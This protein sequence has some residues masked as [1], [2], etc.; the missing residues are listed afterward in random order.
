MSKPA[1][2]RRTAAPKKRRKPSAKNPKPRIP[3][4]PT[5]TA[6]HEAGHAVI[7]RALTLACSGASNL[8]DYEDWSAGHAVVL[9]PYATV[10]EWEQ[11]G[12][13]RRAE[14]MWYGHI[15][16][17]MAGAEAEAILLGRAQGGDGKDRVV[18]WRL[19]DH[20]T[21]VP[22]IEEV[23]PDVP[24]ERV[25]VYSDELQRR[26]QVIEARL[27]RMTRMLVRHHR[28]RIEV[29]A[30]ALLAKGRLSRTRIDA[31]VKAQ[32]SGTGRSP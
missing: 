9:D 18:I 20:V 2:K 17:L 11:R 23:G 7:A 8:V 21:G 10:A 24:R 28:P 12:K 25:W 30:K 19:I 14:A 26:R 6:Y 22:Y 31:L 5:H 1:K 13:F 15:I 27:R 32:S 4:D 16:A 3:N 29:V